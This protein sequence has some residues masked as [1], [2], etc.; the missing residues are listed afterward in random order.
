M[1]DDYKIFGAGPGGLYTAWRLITGGK[2][3]SGDTVELFEW[4]D[5]S[6]EEGQGTRP[7]AGRICS[8]HHNGDP[9]QSYIEVGGMRF[10]QYD[11]DTNA[12]HFLVTRTVC[13]LGLDDQ[14]VPFLTTTDPLFYLRGEAFYECQLEAGEVKAPYNTGEAAKPA[15]ALYTKVSKILE[16]GNDVGSR[17]DNCTFY[18]SGKLSGV[19]SFVYRDGDV[20]SN[21]G[22]WNFFYDQAGN[23]GF[24]YA[25]DAGGYSSNVIN[26]NAAN[27][28]VYNDE[29][30]P[31]GAFVALEGGYS[32]LLVELYEQTKAEA[33]KAGISFTLSQKQRLHS[34][35][36]EDGAIRYRTATAD[37]PFTPGT[38]V[39]AA[40]IAFLAMPKHAIELV[41]QATRY[42]DMAG[43]EDFLNAQPVQLALGGVLEQPSYKI[44][45]F[46]DREWWL[47]A[48]HPPHLVNRPS[49]DGASAGEADDNV[50]GP[51]ITDLPLR[52]I[53]YFG[54]NA[55]DKDGPPVYGMLASYDDMRFT[56]FWQKMEL[57]ADARRETP[58]NQ[59]YQALEGPK[60]A[61]AEMERMLRLQLA[62]VHYGDPD[63]AYQIPEALETVYM[64]WSLNPFGAGYHAWAA[65]Y[66]ICEV[67]Q[68]V[69][70]PTALAGG[71]EA[72]VF[73]VGSAYSNDQAW[74]E[75]AFCTAESVLHDFLHYPQIA[76]D[77]YP[78][79]C[80]SCS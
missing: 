32:R 63:A 69:R 78:L 26:W 73:I 54:D 15:S 19:N 6:F 55:T 13:K 5:Y 50:Y 10:E 49:C 44:A 53:Y 11:K 56:Q 51:T 3:T 59:D 33:A 45:M 68:T 72:P 48:T 21:I 52:Q 35:W 29:F 28:A 34:I 1:A 74:V 75:G 12:G 8:Y 16:Q 61:P 14:V 60:Q 23:E 42:A 9:T 30:T 37:A 70:N 2:L 27:A 31:G 66:D 77:E 58:L 7:P 25:A 41:A 65:H 18:S 38:D 22:Y 24:Q 80:G 64:D 43:K 62:K 47:D 39:G 76:P 79:I 17:I 4:G 40:S 67:M 71:S 20:T 57:P 36:L 46:F